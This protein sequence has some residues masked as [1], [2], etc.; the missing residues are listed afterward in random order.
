MPS[1]STSLATLRPDLGG[2]LQEFDLAASQAGFVGL[3]IYPPFEAQKK[4]G[5]F[6][7]IPLEE[8]LRKR[9][10]KRSAGGSY[11]R[12]EW[13]FTDEVFVCKENGVEEPVDDDEAEIYAEYFDAELIAAQLARDAVLRGHEERVIDGVTDTGIR[14]GAPL[15]TAVGTAW[16]VIATATPIAD[17]RGAMELV[18]DGS[19]LIANAMIVSWKRYNVLKDVAE[20]IDRIK[21]SGHDDPKKGNI[22]R[23]AMAAVFGLDRIIVAG[24]QNNTADQGQAA[25]LASI[26][27]DARVQICKVAV[28]NN[29]KEPCIGRTIHWGGGGSSVGGVME[30]YRDETVRSDIIR[31]RMDSDEKRLYTEAGHLLTGV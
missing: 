16:T 11:N 7:R 14:T 29:I 27:P 9:D 18:Y 6:G 19:G 22:T 4:S 28:T 2:S 15:T 25:S 26:W 20:I 3:E 13:K 5:K 31:N 1:P 12:G 24:S 21:Y 8:L 30:S 23:Q 10:T 17:V